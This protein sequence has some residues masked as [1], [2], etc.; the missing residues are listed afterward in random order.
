[1][2]Q[3]AAYELHPD[4]VHYTTCFLDGLKP[5]VRVLV[6]IQQPPDLDTAYS[7]ALLYEEL[8]DSALS[9]PSN[10][11]T[12]GSNRRYH[13]VPVAAAPPPSPAKWISRTVEEKR[14][15]ELARP[16]VEDKWTNL[17]AYRRS[18]GLCFVCGER[19]SKEHQC[20]AAI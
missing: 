4:P 13:Q 15:Q 18:K 8:G 12:S 1:M 17:K 5:A 10:G 14:L 6:A 3:I 19:W 9:L 11:S 20:K 7:L 16:S 2:D